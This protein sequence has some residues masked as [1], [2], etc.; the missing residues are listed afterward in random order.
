MVDF[1]RKIDQKITSILVKSKQKIDRKMSRNCLKIEHLIVIFGQSTD[2]V[3]KWS[4][5]SR[6]TG[7]DVTRQSTRGSSN[8]AHE[9]NFIDDI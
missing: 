8:E 9:A 7:G 3:M 6:R 5:Y 4:P 2:L 1:T